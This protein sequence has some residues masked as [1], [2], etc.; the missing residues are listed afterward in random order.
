MSILQGGPVIE[1]ADAYYKVGQT[2][3]VWT[4]GISQTYGDV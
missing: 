1:V 4:H 2:T 3:P